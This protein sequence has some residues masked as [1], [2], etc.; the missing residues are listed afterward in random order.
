MVDD[1]PEATT[2]PPEP[3]R[4]KRAPPT[5]DLE[6]SEVSGETRDAGGDTPN[7][8]DDAKN[9]GDD[10]KPEPVSRDARA[11]ISP[12][13]ISPWVI[14][15]VSGA[16]AAALVIGVAWMLGWPAPAPPGAP[17]A[18]AI[19]DLAA[20]VA[21][22]ESKIGKPATPD[23][24]VTGRVE[25][26]EKSVAALRGEFAGLRAQS[27]KLATALN[28]AKA[29]PREAAAAV[30]LSA[31]NER[32]AQIERA[33]RAQSAEIAQEGAK[34]ADDMPLRRV[35]AAALLDVLVRIGDP[36]PAALAAA[37]S[38]TDN[39]DALKPLDGFAASGVPSANALSREL[40]TLVP[41]LT[42]PAPE[43]TTGAGLV[44]RLQAGAAKL[45]R[46]ERTDTVG[47]DRG[48]VVA[49]VTAAALR[50]DFNEARR[51]LNTLAAP[52]RAAAQAWLDKADARDAALA[53]SRKF[54]ADA[55]AALA[56][57]AP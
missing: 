21:S 43:S 28:D 10:V 33:T 6:A 1:T 17:Q 38:L 11:V 52:D 23:P 4:A 48:A 34:P 14:A 50:N 55:M 41:K 19:D 46:I 31:I 57:P 20:R 37:K 2:S 16:V 56:K 7:T 27:E 49:R 42:P 15:P 32:I 18:A 47:T 9:M 3:A 5:I 39:P 12:S 51:E 44:D 13:V 24:A 40:L 26:L 35:V 53:T 8:G 36:Y 25:A 22:V 45:V 54:A 29:T 30:D